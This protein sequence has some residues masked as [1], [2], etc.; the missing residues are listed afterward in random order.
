MRDTEAGAAECAAAG[1]PTI[2]DEPIE[3]FKQVY[4][5]DPF[6]NRV[7]LNSMCD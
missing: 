5:C 2:T 4:V 3:G 1:Y 7:A 6:G